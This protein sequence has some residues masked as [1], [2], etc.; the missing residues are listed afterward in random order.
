MMGSGTMETMT[1][2]STSATSD[3]TSTMD[4]S[5]DDDS[6]MMMM[7]F[8]SDY[9]GAPVLFST[10]SAATGGK[11]FAIFVFLFVLAFFFRGL[12]FLSAYIEQ[13]IFIDHESAFRLVDNV[14]SSRSSD[15][16]SDD[17]KKEQ[18]VLTKESL[19]KQTVLGRFFDYSL[20]GIYRDFIRLLLAFVSVM[21][22][23][24]LMLA[25]MSFVIVYF[26]AVVLGLSF[27]EI[28]FRRL[29]YALEIKPSHS[30]CE[31]LH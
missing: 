21:V 4:M 28:F 25:V 26:F 15:L 13:K 12:S 31:S 11:C 3:A 10:L 6:S 24:A 29:A 22:G 18:E 9:N 1:I 2:S 19:R 14:D 17:L 7:Y 23:Y 5:S 8:S 27:A 20:V 16:E 30:I